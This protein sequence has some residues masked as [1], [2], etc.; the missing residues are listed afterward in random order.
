[1]PELLGSPYTQAEG[2][3]LYFAVLTDRQF[4]LAFFTDIGNPFTVYGAYGFL[5][6][7]PFAGWTLIVESSKE[8]LF[9]AIQAIIR[10]YSD[11]FGYTTNLPLSA[12]APPPIP[13]TITPDDSV[14]SLQPLSFP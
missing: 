4:G 13:V 11:S 9:A 5:G 12:T 7:Y 8:A 14:I 10:P 1:M 2:L 6:Q 3:T